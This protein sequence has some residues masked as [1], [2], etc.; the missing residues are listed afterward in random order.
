[1]RQRRKIEPVESRNEAIDSLRGGAILLMIIDHFSVILF[2]IPI[3]PDTIRFATRLSLPI[4]AILLGSLLMENRAFLDASTG[5]RRWVRTTPAQNRRFLQI[6][7]ASIAISFV[8][9]P[10]FQK[11]DILASF[12]L[13]YLIFMVLGNRFIVLYGAIL[14]Y[15]FDV[16][17]QVFDYPITIVVSL[18]SVGMIL[19]R[20]GLSIA[21]VCSLLLAAY[22]IAVVP[23][24]MSI[25]LAFSLPATLLCG[26]AK[27][28]P[29][30]S[31]RWLAI[32]GRYPLRVYVIQ[33]Y[34]IFAL[35]QVLILIL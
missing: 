28:W 34:A 31:N 20:N 33:F 30:M 9:C 5:F 3:A 11:I 4:F 18:V 10:Y 16:S 26:L 14:L 19:R 21:L 12:S 2:D 23:P 8:Y 22:G 27:S 1:M 6:T 15:P 32:M 7:L 24:P 25:V 29:E 35:R 13:V 17:G